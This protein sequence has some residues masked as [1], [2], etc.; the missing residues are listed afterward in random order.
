[1]TDCGGSF[2]RLLLRNQVC[3]FRGRLDIPAASEQRCATAIFAGSSGCHQHNIHLMHHILGVDPCACPWPE[4]GACFPSHVDY[5]MAVVAL[6]RMHGEGMLARVSFCLAL[7]G[8]IL[9][10]D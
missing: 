2:R 1:M 5:E 10:L 7:D 8:S 6:K 9:L 4:M 3:H